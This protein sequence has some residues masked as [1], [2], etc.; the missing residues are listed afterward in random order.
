MKRAQEDAVKAMLE[1]LG[2]TFCRGLHCN[3]TSWHG[4]TGK[5]KI[6]NVGKFK[7]ITD[8]VD[9]DSNILAVPSPLV[10]SAINNEY[11]FPLVNDKR[12]NDLKSKFQILLSTEEMVTLAQVRAIIDS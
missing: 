12:W 6:F 8:A 1:A 9:G 5:E 11:I 4:P 7:K 2:A 10:F 3:Y